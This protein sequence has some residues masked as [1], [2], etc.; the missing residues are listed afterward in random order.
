MVM[1]EFKLD[2]LA[3]GKR[4]LVAGY[5]RGLSIAVHGTAAPTMQEWTAYF[6]GIRK[7]I[8]DCHGLLVFSIGGG[9]DAVQRRY[10]ADFFN[11]P[12]RRPLPAAILTNSVFVRGVVTAVA[13]LS[14]Q[15]LAAFSPSDLKGA[16]H[17]LRSPLVAEDVARHLETICKTMDFSFC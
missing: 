15:K 1:E 5:C 7:N 3:N 13:W 17:F 8:A 12:G 11:Q 6:D 10:A 14:P 2:P 9:P 4:N 16:L